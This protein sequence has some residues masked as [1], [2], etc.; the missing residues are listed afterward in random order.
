M[1]CFFVVVFC[2]GF[3]FL[4]SYSDFCFQLKVKNNLLITDLGMKMPYNQSLSSKLKKEKDPSISLEK[5]PPQTFTKH[6]LH[7]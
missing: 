6:L 7:Y 4:V 5:V 2:F 1:G 3:S